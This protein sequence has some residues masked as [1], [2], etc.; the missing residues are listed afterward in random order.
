MEGKAI[1][2]TAISQMIEPNATTERKI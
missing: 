1:P 2:G